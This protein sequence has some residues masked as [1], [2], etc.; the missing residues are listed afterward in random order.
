MQLIKF[1]KVLTL[2][3]LL[4]LFLTGIA[5]SQ[6]SL[7]VSEQWKKLKITLERRNDLVSVIRKELGKAGTDIRREAD[8]ASIYSQRLSTALNQQV[9]LNQLA[10]DSLVRLNNNLKS[11]MGRTFVL[12]ESQPD[13]V[14]EK[15]LPYLAQ[16][17]GIE[18]RIHA[19]SRDFNVI[20]LEKGRPECCFQQETGEDRAPQ[21]RF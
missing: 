12:L 11:C 2:I 17:E 6:D 15:T 13:K 8:S 10:I 20:C 16:I 14:K 19:A 3:F 4:H 21:I 7:L 5:H 18:N 9:A 1:R